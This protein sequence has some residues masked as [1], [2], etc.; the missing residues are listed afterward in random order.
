MTLAIWLAAATM[1]Y[2]GVLVRALAPEHL[3]YPVG[4][5]CYATA[6]FA[7]VVGVL[8]SLVDLFTMAANG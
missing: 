5:F 4:L 2:A 3:R 8:V 6:A 7:G 1:G